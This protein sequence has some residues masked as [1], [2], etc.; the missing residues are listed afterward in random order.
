MVRGGG[1]YALPSGSAGNCTPLVWLTSLNSTS[2]Y[3]LGSRRPT[4]RPPVRPIFRQ[5]PALL[6]RLDSGLLHFRT[7][8]L[9]SIR[10]CH[11][12]FHLPVVPVGCLRR[13]LL[14]QSTLLFL[15][16]TAVS[17]MGFPFGLSIKRIVQSLTDFIHLGR[18]YRNFFLTLL[19]SG[20]R[21]MGLLRG[22]FCS[23]SSMPTTIVCWLLPVAVGTPHSGSFRSHL[24]LLRGFPWDSPLVRM[25]CNFLHFPTD[26]L[27][28]CAYRFY[29]RFCLWSDP[30]GFPS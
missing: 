13:C 4:F 25:L 15:S 9:T 7:G 16:L 19:R 17:P 14:L 8:L 26:L 23:G 5:S 2:L 27:R 11:G 6:L 1:G 30:S 10:T 21:L 12:R 22:H 29:L 3:S 24:L 28:L 18:E 20:Y